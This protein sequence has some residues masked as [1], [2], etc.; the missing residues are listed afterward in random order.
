MKRYVIAILAIFTIMVLGVLLIGG[1]SSDNSAAKKAQQE[2]AATPTIKPLHE[3]AGSSASKVV[4]TVQGTIVGDD[5]FRSIRT[6]VARDFR[7]VEVLDSYSNRVEKTQEFPN[8]QE[9]FDTFLRALEQAGFQKAQKSTSVD[10]RGVCPTGNRTIYEL[11]DGTTQVQRT[12]ATS[13]G[14]KFGSFGGVSSTVELLFQ[15]QITGYPQFVSGVKL[16]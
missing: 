11:I 1:R 2:A 3:F 10:E 7:R 13:C 4:Y 9:A 15:R 5:Q 14:S 12:W 6:T 16:F 8:T